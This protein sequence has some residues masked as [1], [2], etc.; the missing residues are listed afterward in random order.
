VGEPGEF[1][2]SHVSLENGKGI[3]VANSIGNAIENTTLEEKLVIV[4]SDGT[5]T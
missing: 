1:Y 4:G 5:A 3:T 2:L